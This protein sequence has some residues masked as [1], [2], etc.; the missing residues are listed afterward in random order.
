[1]PLVVP[2]LGETSVIDFDPSQ[3]EFFSPQE[4]S[5]GE[6]LGRGPLIQAEPV[7][8]RHK[9]EL[10]AEY[11]RLF[12]QVT[13][14]G[15]YVDA[16]AGPQEPT[17]PETWAAKRVLELEPLW[18]RHF[19]LY[20]VEPP[21]CELL[22][23]L[24]HSHPTRDIHVQ[25]ADFNIAVDGLL[26]DGGI[27]EKEATFCLLDQRTFECDWATVQKL[28]RHKQGR[29]IELFYFLAN[30]WLDRAI[31]GTTKNR[32][33][34]RRWWG[35]DGW[36]AFMALGRGDRPPAFAGRFRGE[37]GYAFVNPFPIYDAQEGGRAMYYMIHAADH[38]EAPKFMSRA[39][40]AVV[41][42]LPRPPEPSLFED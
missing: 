15:T 14:H 7:H 22:E 16:F 20:D 33:Q 39:Y 3:R 6:L 13:K 11:L 29:K 5:R 26:K 27:D 41:N 31:S 17:A 1:V 4:T 12:Q 10:V 19:W 42:R 24:R 34:I 23:Q 37:L 38:E 2:R 18:L 21:K 25:R 8:T 9:A 35:G 36:E 32:E 28:A 30:W 40:A